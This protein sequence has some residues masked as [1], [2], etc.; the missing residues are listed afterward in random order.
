MSVSYRQAEHTLYSFPVN[1]MRWQE[2][3]L[4]LSALR[5]ETDCHA[6]NYETS[7]AAEGTHSEPV[8]S[9][10]VLVETAEN[11]LRGLAKK[12]VPIM[13]LRNFLKIAQDERYRTMYYIMEMFYFEHWKLYE[14]AEH[15]RKSVKTLARRKHELVALT[16]EELEKGVSESEYVSRQKTQ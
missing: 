8:H 11:T 15:F 5:A 16:I 9:Y 6:Q 1:L 7:H 12:T 14:V 4:N 10:Y 13:R 2:A 3:A